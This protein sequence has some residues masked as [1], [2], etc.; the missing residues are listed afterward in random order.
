MKIA[1]ALSLAATLSAGATPLPLRSL[2]R[3]CAGKARLQLTL[4]PLP[5]GVEIVA[6]AQDGRLIGTAAPFALRAGQRA[7]TFSFPLRDGRGPV[8]VRL[9]AKQYGAAERAP[10]PAEVIE[11]KVVC[12]R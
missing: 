7:G 9:A 12:A 2:E 6:Y 5:R 11:A 10:S 1:L 4:G 3:V 8:A